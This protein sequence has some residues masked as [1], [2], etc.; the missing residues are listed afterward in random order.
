MNTAAVPLPDP[1]PGWFG[2]A[3]RPS[4]GW[5]H[6]PPAA[7]TDAAAAATGVLICGPL[8]PEA[9]GVHRTL[10]V[11]AEGLARAG[12]PTMRFD[13]DGTGDAAGDELDPD[14][15]EAW[16]RTVR[17]AMATGAVRLGVSRW[18][19]VGVRLGAALAARVAAGRDDVDPSHAFYLGY[20]MAKAVTAL[21]LDKDYRQDQALDW[22]HLTR[23]EI[24]HGPSRAAAR[25]VGATDPAVAG[26]L[27]RRD[28]LPG[29]ETP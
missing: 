27:P 9:M 6:R 20:E 23:P 4:L 13:Y 19:L 1:V 3:G 10:R 28:P 26:E 24:A 8:G 18:I 7:M 2:P 17:D 15:L 22:G 29:E 5:V 25:V 16:L 11:L 21:S 14:R 12:L